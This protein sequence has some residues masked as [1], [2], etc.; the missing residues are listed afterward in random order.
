MEALAAMASALDVEIRLHGSV[1]AVL[2]HAV[3]ERRTPASLFDLVPPLSDIDVLV[4]EPH[5]IPKV[6]AAIAQAFPIGSFF[7]WEIR[8]P[9]QLGGYREHAHV[10]LHGQ[11]E[12]IFVPWEGYEG[13]A[14]QEEPTSPGAVVSLEPEGRLRAS[15]V[16]DPH[17]RGIWAAWLPQTPT[18]GEA[19]IHGALRDLLYLARMLTPGQ[20]QQSPLQDLKRNLLE[21]GGINVAQALRRVP[22]ERRR[23]L[24][25]LLKYLLGR[26]APLFGESP[27]HLGSFL[28][29]RFWSDLRLEIRHPV[30]EE[31]VR[32]VLLPE[33]PPFKAVVLPQR[34]AGRRVR[35]IVQVHELEPNVGKEKSRFLERWS[36]L[37]QIQPTELAALQSSSQTS[38]MFLSPVVSLAVDGPSDPGCCLYRDFSQGI[39]EIAWVEPSPPGTRIRPLH[40]LVRV[41]E[42]G[43]LCFAHAYLTAGRASSLRLDYGFLSVLAGRG[44][45]VEVLGLGSQP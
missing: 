21:V 30:F 13:L 5:Q 40:A 44:R 11:P 14:A 39:A 23:T 20:E 2:L 26:A 22:S 3:R 36:A 7:H 41:P 31:V 10:R 19:G 34:A 16:G 28:G 45:T 12:V 17:P 29:E 35:R 37:L 43:D 4:P 1:A 33:V 18:L 6:R 27:L 15:L 32:L 9:G 25:A 8:C 24:F 38:G 42:L